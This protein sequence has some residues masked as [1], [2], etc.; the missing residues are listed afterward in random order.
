MSEDK[1]PTSPA[2]SESP[3]ASEDAQASSN[4]T[5]TATDDNAAQ[6][7]DD[8]ASEPSGDESPQATSSDQDGAVDV[9]ETTADEH[10]EQRKEPEQGQGEAPRRGAD[11]KV[12]RGRSR[13]LLRFRRERREKGPR[14]KKPRKKRRRRLQPP[15][16]FRRELITIPNILTYLRIA[17]LPLILF[18]L[19]RDNR[20][21]SFVAGCFFSAACFTDFFDGYFARKFNQITVLGKLLDPLADKLIVSATLIVMIPM[22]RVPSWLVIILLAREFAITG[23]RGIAASEDMVIAS[24]PLAKFKT[25]FQMLAIFCLLI[26]YSYQINYFGLISLEA[27]FHRM[28]MALLYLSLFFSIVSAIDYFWKFAQAINRRYEESQEVEG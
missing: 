1:D 3:A 27:S 17:M 6:V 8:T 2:S 23:L 21:S 18:A 15:T 22:G 11:G 19:D 24:A 20:W 25:A 16:D 10:D 12:G 5:A 4:D 13:R 14:E 28:G 9:S 26:H 7:G